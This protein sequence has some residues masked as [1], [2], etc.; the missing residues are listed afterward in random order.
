M[1]IKNN[2]VYL[3]E[4]GNAILGFCKVKT[5]DVDEEFGGGYEFANRDGKKAKHALA[6]NRAIR[7]VKTQFVNVFNALKLYGKKILDSQG[8]IDPKKFLEFETAIQRKKAKSDKIDINE[9]DNLLKIKDLKIEMIDSDI[10]NKL[11]IGNE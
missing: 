1:K 9:T 10:A 6:K 11:R 2:V 7:Q 8:N 3:W 4:E 5:K